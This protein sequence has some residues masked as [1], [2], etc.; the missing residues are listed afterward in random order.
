MA[1]C[2]GTPAVTSSRNS[3]TTAPRRVAGPSSANRPSACGRVIRARS[4]SDISTKNRISSPRGT[5]ARPRRAAARAGAALA[6]S[7]QT[8]VRPLFASMS[9]VRWVYATRLPSGATATS[10]IRS[11]RTMS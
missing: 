8:P 11:M 7:S 1:W 2:S 10:E 9:V 4:K 6:S 5:P 3:A